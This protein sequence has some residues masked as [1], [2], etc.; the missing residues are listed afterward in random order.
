MLNFVWNPQKYWWYKTDD[1]ILP[2]FAHVLL[3]FKYSFSGSHGNFV[4]GVTSSFLFMYLALR[5]C[6]NDCV[7]LKIILVQIFVH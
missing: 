7:I 1:E 6:K 3:T 5:K 4:F 2:V